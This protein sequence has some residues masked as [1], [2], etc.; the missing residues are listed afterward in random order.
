MRGIL[1]AVPVVLLAVSILTLLRS[2]SAETVPLYASRTGLMCQ[3]CHFDPNG[4][5]PRNDFGFAYARNRHSL[6]PE[7]EGSPWHDLDVTNRIGEKMPVYLGVNQRFMLLTNNTTQVKNIDR[8][9]FFNMEN[10]LYV[11]FQP[12]ARLTLVYNR[13]G[14]E[15]DAGTKDA[16]GMIGGFPGNGYLR[17]GRFRNPFGL[18]MDDHTVATRNSFLEFS[19]SA[20]APARF[21]PFDPRTPDEGVEIGMDRSGFFGRVAFTNGGTPVAGNPAILGRAG[22]Y[23]EAKSAKIG[24]NHARFQTGFSIYDSFHKIAIGSR[25][26]ETRW[27]GYGLTHVGP[28]SAL[29]EAA[30]GTDELNVAPVNQNPRALFAELDYAPKRW[31]NTRL[32]YDYLSLLTQDPAA[33]DRGTHQRYA[34][35]IDY[36]PV[37]FAELRGTARQIDHKVDNLPGLEDETQFYVQAHFSY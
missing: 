27:G 12:H 7:P 10:G 2:R 23:A 36:V 21:L 16:F 6:E 37:P 3:S 18:R 35:E 14:F 25:V 15:D 5:G 22:M 13:G 17:L 20:L 32:R 26:R 11:T 9:G 33:K 31:L 1:R 24:F 8:L 34:F 30:G 19:S 29:V 28:V 4:G